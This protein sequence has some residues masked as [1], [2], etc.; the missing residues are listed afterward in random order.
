M[1]KSAVRYPFHSGLLVTTFLVLA[2]LVMS[3]LLT[4]PKAEAAPASVGVLS[5]KVKP[6]TSATSSK[7]SVELG[8]KFS[9]SRDGAIVALQFYRGKK[10][11]K[12][13]KGSL[14]S[15]SGK[16]L[17]RVTFPKS[18]RTGWQTVTLKT[19]VKVKKGVT[20][21]ASYLASDG[22]FP[23][24][25]GAFA[26]SVT[27]NGLTVPKNGGVY[28][29]TTSSKLPN[30]SGRGANY[31]VDVAFVPSAADAD[32]PVAPKPKP[33]PV[34]PA[35]PTPSAPPTA[36]PSPD[37]PAPAAA[38]KRWSLVFSDDFTGNTLDPSRWTTCFD[39][40]YGAC[41][42]STNQGRE[43]YLPSQVSVQNGVAR[44]AAAPLSPPA[45]SGGCYQ[46]SCTYKSGVISTARTRADNGSPYRFSF[47][48]GYAEARLKLPTKRGFFSAFWMLPNDPGFRYDTE[49]DIAEVLG[50]D[51]DT[52]FM[53]YHHSGRTKGYYLNNGDHNNGACQA[54]D[55]TRDFVRIG[56]DW[57]P[58][59]IAWYIDGV[60]CGQYN[61]D[62]STIESGPMHLI[63]QLMVDNKWQRDWGLATAS[64][65]SDQL[66]VD[67][68]RV[69]QQ[70]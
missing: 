46:G 45:S 50:G 16:L 54:K 35:T 36:T 39:W 24:T 62:R 57:Q 5:S 65:A 58:T 30:R 51:P 68:V 11:R 29:Y 4:A 8:M 31:L 14:W 42:D 25:R 23:V 59:H 34:P 19:P 48:Y 9:S 38:G 69:Y 15:S 3:S 22:R 60:K 7:R 2:A 64:G 6:K 61:G 52:I 55:F 17:A 53:T 12:A 63:L 67:Y 27:H 10:Q 32:A 41:A 56:V 26:K 47:T 43:R 70:T 49:I 44:L 40:N 28:R 13:Y 20:Y 37:V 1:R 33:D 18:S 66:Q 21:V